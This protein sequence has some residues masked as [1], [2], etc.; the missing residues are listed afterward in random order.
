[1]CTRRKIKQKNYIDLYFNTF[2]NINSVIHA[3]ILLTLSNGESP[4]IL[5]RKY[6]AANK[7]STVSLNFFPCSSSSLVSI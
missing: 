6:P 4:L 7:R 3:V 2:M 1:M 5:A